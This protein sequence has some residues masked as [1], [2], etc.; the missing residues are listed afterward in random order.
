MVVDSA[1]VVAIGV[2]AR[3][4]AADLAC[5]VLH[6]VHVDVG[7][8]GE[9]R[10]T[11]SDRHSGSA[12]GTVTHGPQS[13]TATGPATPGRPRCTCA[14]SALP[15]SFEKVS[16]QVSDE[17]ES[18]ARNWPDAIRAPFGLGFSARAVSLAASLTDVLP[19]D[20]SPTRR[21]TGRRPRAPQQREGR[22]VSCPAVRGRGADGF[23]HAQVCCVGRRYNNRSILPHL[24][25]ER[26]AH[27]ALSLSNLRRRQTTIEPGSP[28]ARRG[29]VLAT[30]SRP[31]R[32]ACRPAI[33]DCFSGASA[34]IASVVRMFFA[35][36]AAFCSAERVTMVGS[37]IP[38]LT[39]S[40][41]SP[42]STFRPCP[43][44]SRA[45]LLDDDRALE[46]RVERELVDRLLERAQDD[47]GA[48]LLVALELAEPG[49]G[50]RPRH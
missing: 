27:A 20:A 14:A 9:Q 41:T 35:I 26:A 31:C 47:R 10:R 28:L 15:V 50:P 38:D 25:S 7:T 2:R 19:E 16:R 37:M 24:Q 8:A 46:P 29:L 13:G 12:V 44:R 4:L 45:D 48:R 5:L 22:V 17:P 1:C 49:P 11:D 30:S 36:D 18:V 42:E 39:R 43:G 33:A 32:R 23:S 6:R 3:D 40:S 21:Q 34:T